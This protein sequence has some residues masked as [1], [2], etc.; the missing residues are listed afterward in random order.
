MIV[1]ANTPLEKEMITSLQKLMSGS[2]NP[3]IPIYPKH[4]DKIILVHF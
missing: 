4:D 2:S 1:T 3:T